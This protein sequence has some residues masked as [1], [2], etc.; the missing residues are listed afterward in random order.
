MLDMIVWAHT[1]TILKLKL[2]THYFQVDLISFRV[3]K[4]KWLTFLPMCLVAKITVLKVTS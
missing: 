1:C 2:T 3:L 4:I